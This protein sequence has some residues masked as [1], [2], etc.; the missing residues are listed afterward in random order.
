MVDFLDTLIKGNRMFSER[1]RCGANVYFY[2]RVNK[3]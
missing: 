3:K 2:V 1:K